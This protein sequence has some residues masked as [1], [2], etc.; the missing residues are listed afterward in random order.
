MAKKKHS[1]ARSWRQYDHDELVRVSSGGQTLF[2][3]RVDDKTEDGT[4]V[5]IIPFNGHRR[6][7]HVEDDV[8]MARLTP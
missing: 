7:I 6:L 3:G 4:I 8:E 2:E 1:S 5:W